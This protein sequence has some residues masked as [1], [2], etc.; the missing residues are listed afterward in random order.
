MC[1]ESCRA[2][3]KRKK[4]GRGRKDREGRGSGKRER[5]GENKK[6]KGRRKK[7]KKE[8]R[9]GRRGE[10]TSHILFIQLSTDVYTCIIVK[11]LSV[12]NK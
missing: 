5:E 9:G 6:R 11:K 4:E 3:L 12:S 1:Y 7:R 8:K 2:M 10:G